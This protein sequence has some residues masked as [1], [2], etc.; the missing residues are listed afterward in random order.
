MNEPA[1]QPPSNPDPT[2]IYRSTA[3]DHRSARYAEALAKHLW[4][5]HHA[6]DIDASF[7]GVRLSFALSAWRRLAEDYPPAYQALIETR[8]ACEHEFQKSP[9]HATFHDAAAL[10]QVLEETRRTVDLFVSTASAQPEMA[11]SLYKIAEE[12]L[13][14]H[15]C[16]AVCDPFL[17]TSKR[18]EQAA[19]V[20][21]MNKQL[22]ATRDNTENNPP[23]IADKMYTH[24]V[25][26]LV[27]LLVQNN[28]P[29]EAQQAGDT[30][31][32]VVDNERFR[33]EIKGAL[34][35]VFPSSLFDED[36]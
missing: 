30:A 17:E 28:R 22:E 14:A 20:Y 1:W 24:E 16:Y 32:K 3:L 33:D 25:A 10:N 9:E 21:Q 12:H 18:M 6:L 23:E 11:K 8:D 36:N 26:T 13:V 19:E 15:G 4:F 27:A 35:G 2:E 7:Y 29:D 31:L 34:T 5:F